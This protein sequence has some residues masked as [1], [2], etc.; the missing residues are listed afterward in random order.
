MVDRGRMTDQYA[1]QGGYREAGR[2]RSAALEQLAE[3]ARASEGTQAAV[4]HA[5]V[6][7]KQEITDNLEQ[8]VGV[9]QDRS[10]GLAIVA[11][12]TSLFAFMAIATALKGNTAPMTGG[13]K[14]FFVLL[15]LAALAT[16]IAALVR[17]DA[18]KT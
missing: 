12:L 13:E 16:M 9:H 3:K 14:I 11:A 7:S 10:G 15:I 6:L 18:A 5:C 8:A 17:S 4:A 1:K 2:G